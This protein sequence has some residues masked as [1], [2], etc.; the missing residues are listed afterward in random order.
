[1]TYCIIESRKCNDELPL[2]YIILKSWLQEEACR[3]D[4][5][6]Q[7]LCKNIQLAKIII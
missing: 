1:M 7:Y 4:N 3:A 2:S 5:K 6:V